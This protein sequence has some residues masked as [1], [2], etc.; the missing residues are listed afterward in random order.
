MRKLIL[1]ILLSTCKLANAETVISNST[2][3]VNSVNDG[4]TGNSNTGGIVIDGLDISHSKV[5]AQG[6]VQGSGIKMTATRKIN[7]FTELISTLS[8]DIHVRLSHS[9]KLT[10]SGDDNVIP[11]V[12]TEIKEGVLQ[13]TADKGYITTTPLLISIDIP[14]IESVR[15]AGSGEIRLSEVNSETLVLTLEGSGDIQASGNVTFLVIEMSGAGDLELSQL[16]SSNSKVS[17]SGAGDVD[18]NVTGVLDV[19][20][21][22]SGDVIYSGSP[23]K[24]L[25][26]I[27][28][29]GEVLEN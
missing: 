11:L 29:S 13:L 28:G 9:P 22:G 25:T 14:E 18:I 5:N 1:L 21:E 7:N 8:A 3:Q 6:V 27:M 15:L 2:I 20:I 19:V 23:Q 16:T 4:V 17:I 10:I 12:K 26:K 24:I